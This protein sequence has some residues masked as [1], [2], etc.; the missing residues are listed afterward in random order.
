MYG[1]DFQNHFELEYLSI[2]LVLRPSFHKLLFFR[3]YT[4]NKI[5]WNFA[6]QSESISKSIDESE[7]FKIHLK[8]LGSFPHRISIFDGV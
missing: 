7:G 2:L 4:A 8:S 1:L 3:F 5:A 6:K